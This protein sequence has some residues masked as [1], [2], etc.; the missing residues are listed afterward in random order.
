MEDG[1]VYAEKVNWHSTEDSA[2][3]DPVPLF[4]TSITV[5]DAE[6]APSFTLSV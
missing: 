3:I 6:V 2:I 4:A 5:V 1:S